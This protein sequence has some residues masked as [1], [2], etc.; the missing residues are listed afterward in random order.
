MGGV[1]D[2]NKKEIKLINLER[3]PS[4]IDQYQK[5]KLAL[6]LDDVSKNVP[7]YNK[8]NNKTALDSLPIVN[9][10]IINANYNVFLSDKYLRKNLKKVS[11]SGSTGIPFVIFHNPEKVKRQIADMLYFNELCGYTIEQKLI[12]LRIWNE[13]NRLNF[14][15]KSIKNIL[16]IDTANLSIEDTKR[17]IKKISNSKTTYSILSYASS[18]E[19]LERNLIAMKV[20]KVVGKISCIIS[21]AEAL[22]IRT[23]RNIEQIFG[24]SV[25]SR[26][27]NSENGFIAHQIP[28]FEENYFINDASFLVEFL[29]LNSDEPVANGEPGRIIV[30]DLFNNA[31]PLIRYDTGDIGVRN[32]INGKAVIKR[33]EGR[34]L[35]FILATNGQMVSPHV[36]DYS[37]RTIQGIKQFQ[38]IQIDETKYVLKLNVNYNKNFD[39]I[40]E[41]ASNNLKS[42]LGKNAIISVESVNEIPLLDSG[43]RSIVV[44]QWNKI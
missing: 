28:G 6:L 34:K 31:L 29:S 23:K 5:E 37:L 44:N 35:D 9:K 21:M 38:L 19:L 36:V 8:Y 11:T 7:F 39:S 26:Y 32:S 33:V 1:I 10:N 15:Q 18:L 40:K 17:I 41:L 24:C 30:T 42:F 27:S 13:I 25:Y 20:T 4:R 22:P 16:P 3:D 12:Y 43:K 14:F 2:K